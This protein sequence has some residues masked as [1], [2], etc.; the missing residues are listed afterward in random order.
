VTVTLAVARSRGIAARAAGTAVALVAIAVLGLAAAFPRALATTDPDAVDP[1]AALTPPS[2]GHWFGADQLGRDVFSR[3]V[4][5]AQPSLLIGVGATLIA[6]VAGVFLGLF[7]AL[8]G[9]HLEDAMLRILDVLLAFPSLLLALLVVTLVGPSTSSAILAIACAS[10]PGYAR[11]LR[12]QALVV[13]GSGYVEAAV[14]LGVPWT[15]AVLRHVLPN[16]L[17]PL[18]VLATIGVG[19]AIVAGAGLSFLGV[20]SPPPAPEWGAMLSDGRDYLDLAWWTAVFPG[21]AI[22]VSVIAL[23]VVGRRLQG[24]ARRSV[25]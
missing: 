16:S 11:M 7:G 20:G 17:T 1:A 23:T 5:G 22:T 21:A 4:Y 24:W 14:G 10:A 12:G 8:A 3:V 19:E 2:A 15:R 25:G 6:I 18:L 9:R 13:K